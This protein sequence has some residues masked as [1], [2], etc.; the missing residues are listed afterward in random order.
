MNDAAQTTDFPSVGAKL[1]D[2]ISR[3][4]HTFMHLRAWTRNIFCVS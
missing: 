1:F 3:W 4:T 2:C